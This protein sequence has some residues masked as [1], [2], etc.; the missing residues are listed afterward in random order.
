MVYIIAL[1]S[2]NCS[3]QSLAALGHTPPTTTVGCSGYIIPP[4]HTM[5]CSPR[6]SLVQS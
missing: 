3:L 1:Y 2:L 5:G 4:G 6:L